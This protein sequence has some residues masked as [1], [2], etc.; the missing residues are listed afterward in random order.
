MAT[1]LTKKASNFFVWVILGLLLVALAGFGVT[2][3]TGGASV[4]GRVGSAEITAEDYFRAIDNEIREQS[5]LRGEPVRFVDLQAAGTDAQIRNLLIARAALLSEAREMGLSVGDE[6]IAEQIRAIPNFRAADGFN[7]EAY[8]FELARS[9]LTPAEFETDIREDTTRSLLQ[10][11]VISGVAAPGLLAETLTAVQT[12]RRDFSIVRIAENQLDAELSAPDADDLQ[13]YYDENGDDFARPSVRQITYAWVT[14]EMIMD[15][16][17]IDEATLRRL[18]DQRADLYVRPERRLVERLVFPDAEAADAA[19]AALDAGETDFNALVEARGLS[20]DDI[21]LGDARREDLTEAAA[22][23]V[24]ADDA[25]EIVG[26]VDSAFGPA[27]FRINAVLAATE[28]SFEDALPDLR[29]ELAVDA[30]RR[31]IAQ[32]REPIEDALAGGATLEDLPGETLMVLGNID[33][34]DESDDGIAA[35]D[36]FRDAASD[37]QDGDFPEALELSDGGLFALRLDGV[38][39]ETVPPLA[40]IEDE[41]AVSWEDAA[42][43]DALEARAQDLLSEIATLGASFED[44]GLE[45]QIE[46]GIGRQDFI[47]GAPPSLVPLVFDLE[48]V[49]DM[50]VVPGS[51]EALIVRL[52]AIQSG[53]VNDPEVAAMLDRVQQQVNQSVAQD[54]FEGFGQAM[55]AEVGLT[56]NQQVIN[57]VHISFP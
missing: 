9:G 16:M 51:G 10:V 30:A 17:E 55:E 19:R 34:S 14:P 57:A 4:V 20:L 13:S 28:V 44:Q 31:T 38:I 37:V 45:A 6:T 26:P 52:D 22:A 41:V 43:R 24:F 56:L 11:A 50:A 7:R 48:S 1:K 25:D 40:E 49:G 23:A 5:A 36:N 35:Y 54:L 29:A 33:F 15:D 2:S 47:P 42:L 32:E 21:D 39:P 46:T 8:E 53:N 12:E 3:F 27:L 18:Y